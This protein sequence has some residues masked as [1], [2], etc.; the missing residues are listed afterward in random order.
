MNLRHPCISGTIGVVSSQLNV[1]KTVGIDWS[2]NLL[3]IVIS[4]S[5]SWW[6]S[7]AKAKAIV[8]LVMGEIFESEIENNFLLFTSRY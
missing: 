8:G 1:V 7:T 2:D 3:S 5:P 6:S 4:T